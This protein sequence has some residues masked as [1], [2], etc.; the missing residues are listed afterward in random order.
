MTPPNQPDT[1]SGTTHPAAAPTLLA[2]MRTALA[3]RLVESGLEELNI[4]WRFRV[5]VLAFGMPF[6]AYIVWSAAQQ[7]ILEKDHVRDRARSNA[8]LIAARFE[9][10]IEQVDRLLAAVSQS[11]GPHLSSP[12]ETLDLVQGMRGYLPKSV[13]NL[14]VWSLTGNSIASLDRRSSTRSV[15][16]ADRNYFRDAI[17]RRDL[18]FEGPIRSRSTGVDI[19]Q[20]ARPIIGAKG[21]VLGVLTM[22]VRAAQ[23]I[24]QLDPDGM[25]TDQ[26]LITIL[27]DKGTIVSRSSDAD[28]WV[29]R[30]VG[31]LPGLAAAFSARSGTREE[32]GIDGQRRLAGY[33]V[34]TK[35]PWIVMVGE[36]IEKVLGPVSDRLLNNL[37]IGV[38]IFALALLIAG[39]IASWTTTPLIQLAADA[40][41]L[42]SGDLSH[43][44]SVQSGGEIATLATNF[45]SMAKAIESRES[46][47]ATS[48]TQLRAIADNIPEQIT[49]VDR[50]ERYR[51]VNAYA[52]PFKDL[53]PEDVIG[54]TILELRGPE[55]Y[56]AVRPSFQRAM[57]GE[58]FSHERSMVLDGRMQHFFMTYVPDFDTD[59]TVKGVYAFAQDITERKTA[60]L[61]RQES[62][63]RLVTIT[64]NLPAMI[65]YV[66]ENRYFR[67]ANK[68]WEKWFGIPID[69]IIGRPFDRMMP[70]ELASQYDFWFV[71]GMQ[72]EPIE[73]EVEIPSAKYG[74]RWLKCNFIPDID[75]ATGKVR[76]VYGMLH[77]VT[78]GK[79][80][81][82]RLIRLAQFDTLT[83]LANRHQFNETFERVLRE[84]DHD[85]K[86]LAL[87]FLDID[88]FKQ[89]NDRHGHGSGD[90]L[91]KEFA[92]RLADCVRSTDAVARLSGDEFVVLLEGMHSEDE[93]Q[94][95]ARKIIAAV[96]KPF[97]L[98][99]HFICVT[100]SIGI[101]MRAR[102]GESGSVLMKRADEALYEAK[103]AG[104]NTFRLAS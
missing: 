1:A 15:N 90:F 14:G 22:A 5:V 54:K 104:R 21:D 76:G 19:I 72:G 33:A 27:N 96:E 46:A 83:G 53:V 25:I 32:T 39:R 68:A 84:N 62:E 16:V 85:F 30:Q 3:R 89:V 103:R 98:D 101:A 58:S 11:L 18:V 60:E 94:F 91:L 61:L 29:G 31:D 12:D 52:G 41:R 7:A 77:N 26:A 82:Q 34:V 86:P 43:R 51:F 71:R 42:G 99:E 10:H 6:L 37:A 56:E 100:T 8:M 80:A 97:M 81:E 75:E 20:F 50:D 74:S 48:R 66:D 73:C 69:E 92:F 55:A 13:D 88:H 59:R 45:N 9:D 4:R 67:F 95:I 102:P 38:G 23:L 65:C 64:D 70:P 35:W 63:K 57:A 78:K 49:Y 87:M 93:P 79:E 17:A 47:I 2:W 44:S 40:E 28:L 24:G 36:P